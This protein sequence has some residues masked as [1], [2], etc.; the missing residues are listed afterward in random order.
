MEIAVLIFFLAIAVG[1]G[2]LGL[3]ILL[4]IVKNRRRR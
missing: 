2:L 4:R 3:F 1:A